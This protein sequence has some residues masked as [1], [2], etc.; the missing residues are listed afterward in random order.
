MSTRRGA[1]LLFIASLSLLSCRGDRGVQEAQEAQEAQGG[2]QGR[3]KIFAASS[4][5]ALFSAI[6]ERDVSGSTSL[7]FAGSQRLQQQLARGA[8]ADLFATADRRHLDSLMRLGLVADAAPLA[9]GRVALVVP[10]DGS[11][12][13]T[14]LA[15]LPKARCLILAAPEVPAGRYGRAL[16]HRAERLLGEGFAQRALARLCS[17]EGNVRLVRAKLLLGEADAGLIYESDLRRS[18]DGALEPRLRALPLP[19]TLQRP[20]RYWIAT[21]LGS[22]QPRRAARWRARLRSSEGIEL[23]RRFGFEAP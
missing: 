5:R 2:P 15:S 1:R 18:R 13:V 14:D 4:L 12:P 3:L 8:R 6:V 10:A 22:A 23:L 9:V 11:S 17:E 19:P 20:V 16:L 7:Q 21:L